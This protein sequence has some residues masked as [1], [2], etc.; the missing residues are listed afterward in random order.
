MSVQ[1]KI[2]AACLMFVAIIAALGGLAQQQAAQMGRLAISIYDHAFMGMSYVDQAQ[3]EFLR[4]AASHRAPDATLGDKAGR[5][6]L[7]KVVERLDVALERAVSD[8]TRD[9]GK[10]VRA[11]LTA[12]SDAAPADLAKRMAD[13]DLAITRLVKKFSAD[14]LD[15]RDDADALAT[16][17]TRLVLLEIAGAVCLAL[18]VGWVVGRNLSRPLVQLVRVIGGFAAGR[19]DQEVSPRLLR[20]RDEI[21]AVARAASVFREAMQQN[22]QAGED[23]ER[24][25]ATA[26][27]EKR[28]VLR[29]AADKIELETT[30]VTERSGQSSIV[31]AS[32]TEELTASAARVL[33]SV[34]AATEASAT[35]LQ[36]S[37]LVATASEHLSSSAREIAEQISNTAAEIGSTA[38][39]GERARHIIDQLSAAV[40]QI[41]AVARL[42][43]GIAAQTNLLA[44]NATIE[45]ARAGEA[46]RGFAVVAN[47]VKT[48]A[49]QTARST[50]EITRNTG[51][52]QKATHDAVEIVGEMIGRVASIERITHAVATAAEQQTAATNEITRN[53]AG[54][55]EAMRV[56]SGQIGAVT[57]EVHSTD[58]AVTEVC[59]LTADVAE[60][61]LELREV[62]VRIV[63]TSSDA[64]DR[65]RDER[66]PLDEPAT[67]VLDHR[68]L[69]VTCLDLSLGGAQ[70]R[71][72]ETLAE[73]CSV[74][75]LLTGL[76][77]LAARVVRGG[78]LASLRFEWEPEAAPAELQQ[79]LRQSAAA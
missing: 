55:A 67:L 57:Q 43:G 54:T 49:A 63:R 60:R 16:S 28:Q 73:G 75:L 44:L 79:R 11:L 15:A 8:R 76:P 36:R 20:R 31:L 26:E 77:E 64:A 38:R 12:L 46:G 14:G 34:G 39:A 74:V 59:T 70:V 56:V 50:E 78:E 10:Q 9:A 45:A 65:R 6:G 3:E 29:D 62:M 22:A 40:G 21:G 19:L 25:H 52:I 68:R 30:R 5:A 32:R 69:S 23:Q 48:L 27:E 33:A 66:M 71:A 35:A 51:A 37:Q 1:L 24:Q 42:I 4:L 13:T 18:G 61:L 53:V 2:F 72:A 17:S 47:E 41:G 58:A 7:G